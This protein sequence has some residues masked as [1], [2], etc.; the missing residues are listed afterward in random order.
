MSS[1]NE[2]GWQKKPIRW[3]R[4]DT[5]Y[6]SVSFT[7][8]LPAL[9]D[10][11]MT[12]NLFASRVVVGGPAVRLMPNYLRDVAEVSLDDWPGV[13]QMAHPEA[14]RTTVG[15]PGTCPYCGVRTIEGEYRELDKWPVGRIICDSNLLAASRKHFDRVIDSLKGVRQI[16]FQGIDARY[17]SPYCANRLA[18]LDIGVLRLAYDPTVSERDLLRAIALLRRAGIPRDRMRVYVLI[19]YRDNPD[20]AEE[21]LE[22]VFHALGL[23]PLPM[24]YVP[25]DSLTRHYVEPDSGWTDELLTA[26]QRRWFGKYDV[27]TKERGGIV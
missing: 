7:F 15:C 26:V 13:L 4:D 24:R 3:M 21:R 27:A 18:E 2:V 12:K 14:T 8:D 25:L 16:D 20:I 10:E 6:I 5:L 22:I 11:L 23:L 17:V 19:G 9:R 1:R